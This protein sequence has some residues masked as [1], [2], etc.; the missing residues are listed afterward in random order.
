MLRES[1]AQCGAENNA[2]TLVECSIQGG[3]TNGVSIA[4]HLGLLLLADSV[5]QLESRAGSVLCTILP[6]LEWCVVC[7]RL[8]G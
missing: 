3:R 5:L 6:L 2:Y 1:R 7:P 8:V 4:V